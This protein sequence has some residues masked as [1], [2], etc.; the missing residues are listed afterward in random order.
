[1]WEKK[2]KYER[3]RSVVDDTGLNFE[4]AKSEKSEGIIIGMKKHHPSSKAK[5]SICKA[6]IL[7]SQE[8]SIRMPFCKK[9]NRKNTT[10]P[11]RLQVI[12]VMILS[13]VMLNKLE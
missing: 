2:K 11:T 13:L 10:M 7:Y 3:A 4:V 1:V 9:G 12:C 8:R 5:N 6:C